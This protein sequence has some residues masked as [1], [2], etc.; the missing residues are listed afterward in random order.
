MF[1]SKCSTGNF[2]TTASPLAKSRYLECWDLFQLLDGT[3]EV[4]T[5]LNQKS[6]T[7]ATHHSRN[8]WRLS[9]TQS[10][11]HCKNHQSQSRTTFPIRLVRFDR[12]AFD[13]RPPLHSEPPGS[14]RGLHYHASTPSS[15]AIMLQRDNRTHRMLKSILVLL[16]S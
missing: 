9:R 14:S 8:P 10:I 12:R 1:F 2:Q 6:S 16:T 3:A 7:H 15:R 11:N 5:I 13:R 4:T